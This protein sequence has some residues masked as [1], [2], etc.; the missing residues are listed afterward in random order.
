MPSRNRKF[1][2]AQGAGPDLLA[3]RDL[4]VELLLLDVGAFP[5]GTCCATM[6]R[7]DEDQLGLG[8]SQFLMSDQEKRRVRAAIPNKLGGTSFG[9]N[10][11]RTTSQ[12]QFSQ[13]IWP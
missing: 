5:Q 3:A 7:P 6:L 8:S 10:V 13:T 1:A 4:L 12:G 2:A 9:K 11:L